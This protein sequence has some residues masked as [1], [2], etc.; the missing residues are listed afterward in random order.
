[1]GFWP[2]PFTIPVASL[3]VDAKILYFSLLEMKASLNTKEATEGCAFE[4][5]LV[6]G[7]RRCLEGRQSRSHGVPPDRAGTSAGLSGLCSCHWRLR[8]VRLKTMCHICVFKSQ[9]IAT[10][11]PGLKGCK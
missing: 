4:L 1:M 5:C 9:E 11:R 3:A 8:A 2:L 10:A 6:A 7:K